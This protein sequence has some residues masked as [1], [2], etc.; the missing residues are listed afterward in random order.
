LRQV[1]VY[2]WPGFVGLEAN[3]VQAIAA[4][5]LAF[6]EGSLI[7][8]LEPYYKTRMDV[9]RCVRVDSPATELLF[10]IS[11]PK[12]A[13]DLKAEGNAHVRYDSLR[14]FLTQF[15]ENIRFL[16]PIIYM[17]APHL[18]MKTGVRY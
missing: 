14:P 11:P 9:T 2:N 3:M 18:N 1:A 6:K 7:G 17:S 12:T 16:H 10:D 5:D 13:A 4:M 8:I 15:R